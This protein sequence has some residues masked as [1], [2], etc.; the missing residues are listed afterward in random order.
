MREMQRFLFAFGASEKKESYE[1]ISNVLVYRLVLLLIKCVC[2][3]L[4][5]RIA[6]VVYHN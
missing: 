6:Y 1:L 5:Q 2:Y 3:T 4:C